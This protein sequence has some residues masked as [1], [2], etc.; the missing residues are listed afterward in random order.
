MISAAQSGFVNELV[1]KL[2]RTAPT[3][4]PAAVI[5][6]GATD[7]H[8]VFSGAELDGTVRA[9]AWGIKTAFA[10][11]IAACGLSLPVSL[12]SRW[13]NIHQKKPGGQST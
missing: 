5:A 8:R 1:R 6:T 4:E 7:L 2:A 11:T 3:V 13:D 10:I 9:Y 12:L